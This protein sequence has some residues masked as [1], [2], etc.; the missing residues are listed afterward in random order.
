MT[1]AKNRKPD[2]RRSLTDSTIAPPNTTPQNQRFS[3]RTFQGCLTQEMIL[4][5]E[6]YSNVSLVC[7]GPSIDDVGVLK[8][9]MFQEI[10][11]GA[12][13]E[14]VISLMKSWG[15]YRSK[16]PSKKEKRFN[17]IFFCLS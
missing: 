16:T 17:R 14:T 12:G 15:G 2:R 9:T 4:L 6:K 1:F 13:F 3:F 5:N 10:R 7:K 8:D 11:P